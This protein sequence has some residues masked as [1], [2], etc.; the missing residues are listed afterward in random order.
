M[1]WQVHLTA[2]RI[3]AVPPMRALPAVA[4]LILLH[5]PSKWPATSKYRVSKWL[6]GTLDTLKPLV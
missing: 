4:T 1:P 6:I 2:S 5:R 3:A